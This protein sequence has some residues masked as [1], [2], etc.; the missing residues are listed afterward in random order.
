MPIKY[1]S[2]MIETF[3]TLVSYSNG[4]FMMAIFGLVCI[5]LIAFVLVA[6][7]GGKKAK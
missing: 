5:A 6:M 7:F 3:V 4:I 1:F 2:I